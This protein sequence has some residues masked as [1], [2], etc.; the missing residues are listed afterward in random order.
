[1]HNLIEVVRFYEIVLVSYLMGNADM[2]LK[3]FSLI[4][5]GK[6]YRVAPA[7]DMVTTKL[8]MPQDQEELAL[9]LN[10]KKSKLKR[11][12]FETAMTN[13]DLPPKAIKNLFERVLKGTKKWDSLIEKCFV[14]KT[15]RVEFTSIIGYKVQKFSNEI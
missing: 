15:K 12:D 10:G 8:L 3:N 14:S 4:Q 13:A 1:M 9:T 11:G 7:Y 5:D 6:V 2:H